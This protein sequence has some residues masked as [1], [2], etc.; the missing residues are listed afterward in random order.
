MART[1]LAAFFNSPSKDTA[2]PLYPMIK[3]FPISLI[4]M[5]SDEKIETKHLTGLLGNRLLFMSITLIHTTL[6]S[7]CPFD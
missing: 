1:P 5:G 3:S 7:L 4:K 6:F 2:T